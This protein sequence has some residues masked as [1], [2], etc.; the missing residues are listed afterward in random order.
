MAVP[1]PLRPRL[2]PESVRP[3]RHRWRA[4]LPLALLLGMVLLLAHGLQ[5]DPRALPS[6]LVGQPAPVFELPRLEAPDELLASSALR[7][8]PW[9]LNVWASWCGPCREEV[10]QLQQLVE[11]GVTVV[12]LNYKDETAAARRW[13]ESAGHAPFEA[14]VRDADG[15]AALDWGVSAVPETFVIDADGIVRGRF[16]GALTP[17]VLKREFWPLWKK[18]QE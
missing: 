12:G 11:R 6:A 3:A 13:L 1:S 18:V 14:M 7:G 5:R 10:P 17:Q 4:L 2:R 16:V 15:R 9:V 8:R